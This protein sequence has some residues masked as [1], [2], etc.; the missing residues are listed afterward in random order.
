MDF[1]FVGG[2]DTT[3][4]LGW[5]HEVLTSILG[6]TH[7]KVSATTFAGASITVVSVVG[8]IE[9]EVPRGSQIRFRGFTLLGSRRIGVRSSE[10]PEITVRAFSV[11]GSITV[12][13]S[14]D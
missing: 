4:P 6:G 14:P 5:G 1:V 12:N 2:R 11:I 3:L 9:I 10:K 8:G 13:E 7:V